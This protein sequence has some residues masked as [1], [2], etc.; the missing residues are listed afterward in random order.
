MRVR[1]YLSAL[2]G[3]IADAVHLTASGIAAYRSTG[4]KVFESMYLSNL[5]KAYAGLGQLDD[6]R[7]SVDEATTVIE[8]TKETWFEA[9]SIKSVR[10][11]TKE[12]KPARH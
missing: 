2:T 8:R 3:N 12:S 5:A 10:L 1:G 11:C 7:R 4:A 6:A 9:R